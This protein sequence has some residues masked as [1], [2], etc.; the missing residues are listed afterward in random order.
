MW[1][2]SNSQP[3]SGCVSFKQ[4]AAGCCGWTGAQPVGAVSFSPT[5]PPWGRGRKGEGGLSSVAPEGRELVGSGGDNSGHAVWAQ[6]GAP[7]RGW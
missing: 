2:D 1:E 5:A 7:W 3:A 6:P 4:R